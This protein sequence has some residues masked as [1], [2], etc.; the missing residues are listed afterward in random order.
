MKVFKARKT[1]GGSG[2]IQEQVGEVLNCRTSM[3]VMSREQ[4]SLQQHKERRVLLHIKVWSVLQGVIKPLAN[5]VHQERTILH[6]MTMYNHG[7]LP[8]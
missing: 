8:S 4:S 6:P 7:G 2:A 3:F 1:Q 5:R